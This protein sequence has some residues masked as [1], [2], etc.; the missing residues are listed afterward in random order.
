MPYRYLNLDLFYNDHKKNCQGVIYYLILVE[1]HFQCLIQRI[2]WFQLLG[3]DFIQVCQ[4]RLFTCLQSYNKGCYYF[5]QSLFL[6][7][8]FCYIS[9][10]FVLLKF[11]IWNLRRHTLASLKYKL[12][13]SRFTTLPIFSNVHAPYKTLTLKQN[14]MF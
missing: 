5:F 8:I 11:L 10:F 3:I 13:R 6:L 14:A 2:P 4:S 1:I 7:L 12:K 9:L